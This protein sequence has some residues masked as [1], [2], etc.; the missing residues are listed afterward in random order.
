MKNIWY[1]DLQSQKRYE[2]I[3]A[4]FPGWTGNGETVAVLAPHDD[5]AVLGPG[6]LIHA[7]QQNGGRVGVIQFN[8]GS[9]GY[10]QPELKEQIVAIRRREMAASLAL[11]DIPP[12][13]FHCLGF[14]DF[15]G[16]LHLGWKL[17]DGSEGTF[18]QLLK[19]LREWRVTRLVFANGHMEHIDHWAVEMASLFDGPQAGDPVCVDW[20]EPSRIRTYLAYCCWG[21]FSPMDALVSGRDLRIRANWAISVP[22]EVEKRL[23]QAILKFD[24]QSQIIDGIMRAR[25]SRKLPGKA[26]H[27]LE[28][29]LR[30]E[31]RPSFDYAPYHNLV[32]AIDAQTASS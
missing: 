32:A 21:A 29:F 6:Y 30:V 25:Q 13:M 15:S 19:K 2:S 3:D 7:V 18:S 24:T 22:P 26:G 11:L 20:G 9:A 8:D 16:H 31:A 17:L 27:Y 14:P 1:Y 28:L 12:S 5:D 4:I 10:S 23:H